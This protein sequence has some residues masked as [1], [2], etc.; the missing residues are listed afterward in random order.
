MARLTP[1]PYPLRTG[2]KQDAPLVVEQ[3]MIPKQFG[4]LPVGEFDVDLV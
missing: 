3:L 1:Q 2:D 4:D